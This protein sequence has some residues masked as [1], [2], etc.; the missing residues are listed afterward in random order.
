MLNGVSL[1]Y[2]KLSREY[3]CKILIGSVQKLRSRLIIEVA[4]VAKLLSQKIGPIQNRVI[5]F[6]FEKFL[7]HSIGNRARMSVFFV[8]NV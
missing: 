1:P 6:H 7:E 5:I 8:R 2:R 3:S 4:L